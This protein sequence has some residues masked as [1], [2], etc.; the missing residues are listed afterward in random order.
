MLS[1]LPSNC[2]RCG[3]NASSSRRCFPV[4]GHNLSRTERLVGIVDAPD[5]AT[6]QAIGLYA[7]PVNERWRLL[8]PPQ[9]RRKQTEN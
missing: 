6:Q 4:E 7:V 8:A 3:T 1:D 5:A 2:G 9:P